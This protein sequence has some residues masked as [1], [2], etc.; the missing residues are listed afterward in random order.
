M[1]S[2]QPLPSPSGGA[3]RRDDARVVC[4]RRGGEAP[5]RESGRK[6]SIAVAA[7]RKLPDVVDSRRLTPSRF[8][9]GYPNVG[10]GIVGKDMNA[11]SPLPA[12]EPDPGEVLPEVWGSPR[13]CL[14][15]PR[16]VNPD[17]IVLLR[18]L[19]PRERRLFVTGVTPVMPP[20]SLGGGPPLLRQPTAPT[21]VK[22]AL[23]QTGGG[24]PLLPL[25][26]PVAART[27]HPAH[28]VSLHRQ[29]GGPACIRE[30]HTASSLTDPRTGPLPCLVSPTLPRHTAR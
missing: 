18:V 16:R 9:V 21:P 24:G 10:S 17:A 30:S 13:A 25:Q 8:G 27:R 1:T 5:N 14:T 7:A 29:V 2:R 26:V 23:S 4:A 20:T 11:L 19:K 6:A 15:R 22:S 12:R 28:P 3:R